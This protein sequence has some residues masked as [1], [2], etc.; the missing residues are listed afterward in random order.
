[1]HMIK[2]REKMNNSA[3]AQIESGGGQRKFASNGPSGNAS[4]TNAG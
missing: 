3:L 1:M 2:K 4:A